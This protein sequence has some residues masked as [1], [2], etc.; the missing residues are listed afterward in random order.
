MEL[1][2][3]SQQGVGF[4]SE[5]KAKYDAELKAVEQSI[6]DG[7]TQAPAPKAETKEEAETELKA[8]VQKDTL[9]RKKDELERKYGKTVS[10]LWLVRLYPDD[11]MKTYELLEV[12]ILTKE[13]SDLFE[14]R[15]KEIST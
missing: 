2:T 9:E 7:K 14:E 1:L 8:Q 12:P 5:N 15:K 6:K 10:S 13:I 4:T 11:D 3:I